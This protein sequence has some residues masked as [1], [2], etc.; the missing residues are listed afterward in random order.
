MILLWSYLEAIW[1]KGTV[2]P[3]NIQCD[4]CGPGLVQ[5]AAEVKRARR[6]VGMRRVAK[7][8]S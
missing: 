2:S 8:V 6:W 7:T 1:N 5:E 3:E 4:S